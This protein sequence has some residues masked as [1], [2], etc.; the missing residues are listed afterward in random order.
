MDKIKKISK[1]ITYKKETI[2]HEIEINGKK[3]EIYEHINYDYLNNYDYEIVYNTEQFDDLTEDERDFIE[4][5]ETEII[6]LEMGYE[7]I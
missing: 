3:L 1:E 5:H 4:E 6:D 7:T 2:T